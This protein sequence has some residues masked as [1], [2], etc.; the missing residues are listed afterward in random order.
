MLVYKIHQRSGHLVLYCMPVGC[1]NEK[2]FIRDAG[3][4]P[5]SVVHCTFLVVLRVLIVRSLAIA[6]RVTCVVV[7]QMNSVVL[8]A[9]NL[10]IKTTRF[11]DGDLA[12]R[13]PVAR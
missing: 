11:V 6:K 9:P 1:G 13:V 3:A 10:S 2:C 7:R 4:H 12:F 5:E 8:S